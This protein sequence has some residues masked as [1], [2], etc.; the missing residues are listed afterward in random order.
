RA[1]EALWDMGQAYGRLGTRFRKQEGDSYA[2]IVRD[3]PLSSFAD[4]A[5]KRL[6]ELEL[7]IPDP[8]P[9]A[10][11]RMQWE[12]DN[13]VKPGMLSRGLMPLRR[14]PDMS[15]AARSGAP[16][17]TTLRAS[18]PPSVPQPSEGGANSFTG[19]VTAATVTDSTALDTKPD[20][21]A[22]PP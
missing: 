14:G 1:D 10:L 16:A 7:S 21:R 8:D 15:P 6:K 2:R 3:Y 13:R 22:N 18:V 11:A 4:D 20:A 9:T 17:M 19:D 5:K 12:R